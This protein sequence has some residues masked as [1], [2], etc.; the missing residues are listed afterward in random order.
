MACA[1]YLECI[2]KK[3]HEKNKITEYLE[4]AE[5][6]TGVRRLYIALGL[7]IFWALY[8]ILGHGAE[9]ICNSIGFGYPAYKSI[10]AI[11]THHKDDDTKWLTYWVTFAT[12]SIL[13]FFS[14]IIL[15]F[16]PFYWLVKCLF[17][18]WCFAPIANN[19]SQFLYTK[20]IRPIFLKNKDTIDEALDKAKAGVSGLVAEGAAKLA[21]GGKYE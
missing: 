2:D 3:L 13:E 14:E 21:T 10:I 20:F 18:I 9:L 16:V 19:G 15:D 17:L 7:G 4:K 5:K 11:E 8:M 6:A 1:S 12:F